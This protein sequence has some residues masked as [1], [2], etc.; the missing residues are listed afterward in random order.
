MRIL[1]VG[2]GATGGYFGGRLAEAGKDV[3]FLVRPRR[4][5]TLTERGLRIK[6]PTGESVVKPHL[7]TAETLDGVY[8]LVILAV[9]SYTLDEALRDVTPAVGPDSAVVPLL[10]GM[11]HLATLTG[12]FGPDRA[13]GGVCRIHAMLTDDGDVVQFTGMHRI[14]HGRP[15]GEPD[16]RV[17]EALSGAEFVVA[18]STDIVHEMW[19]KWVFLASIGAATTLFGA[20]IGEINSVP[21]GSA[22]TSAI[23]AEA[24]AIAV[25][26]G[27]PPSDGA[28]AFLRAGVVTTER[29]TSTMNR[30]MA[31]GAPLEAEA[32]LA[33]YHAEAE[34]HREKNTKSHTRKL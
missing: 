22:L 19:E 20:S 17:T 14:V 12:A 2:A 27:F 26:A 15:D 11:R 25:A 5:A 6:S 8:D 28:R 21:G 1:I 29:T 31:A 13:Y 30:D 10:N 7:V 33:D 3:S 24:T 16:D 23:A 4:A 34:R 9:K 18:G 32:I